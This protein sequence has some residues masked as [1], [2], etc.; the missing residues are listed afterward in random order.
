MSASDDRSRR[1]TSVDIIIGY[2]LGSSIALE[3]TPAWLQASK[4]RPQ[5]ALSEEIKRLT[6][7]NSSLRQEL[8]YHYIIQ[9]ASIDLARKITNI[10]DS[11]RQAL[12]DYK[13]S[14][15]KIDDEFCRG[16]GV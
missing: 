12:Y 16:T 9:D 6:R 8:V 4:R 10:M 3:A 1:P 14:Q 13:T 2:N 15:R 5:P 11:L 7:E